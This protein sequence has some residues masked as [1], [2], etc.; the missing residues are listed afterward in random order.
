MKT[1]A[2]LLLSLS[3]NATSFAQKEDEEIFFEQKVIVH[4][5]PSTTH[6][7]V[8]TDDVESKTIIVVDYS[9]KTVYTATTSDAVVEI[10]CND[11]LSGAY[12]INLYQTTGNSHYR[13]MK[14]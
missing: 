4:P 13:I 3:S 14:E 7:K 8:V 1:L 2:L 5:N 11:W 6:F 10:Y 9:G 12:I